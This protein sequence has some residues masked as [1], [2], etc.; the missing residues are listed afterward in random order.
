M[1]REGSEKNLNVK[2]YEQYMNE[3][4]LGMLM[5]ISN[6]TRYIYK[7]HTSIQVLFFEMCTLCFKFNI[8]RLLSQN[9]IPWS[10]AGEDNVF[11]KHQLR[12]IMCS[13]I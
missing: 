7:H 8:K 5:S 13:M 6:H 9:N 10:E 1:E 3:Q 12:A 2:R 4:L 11:Y